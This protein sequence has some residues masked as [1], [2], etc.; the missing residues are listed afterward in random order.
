MPG[1]VGSWVRVFVTL[2]HLWMH[3]NGVHLRCIIWMGGNMQTHCHKCGHCLWKC[4]KCGIV[5]CGNCSGTGA[6]C[7][8]CK[9]T[10]LRVDQAK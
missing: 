7:P 1:S 3:L 8:K 4:T 9:L 6:R 5:F 2:G 10:C